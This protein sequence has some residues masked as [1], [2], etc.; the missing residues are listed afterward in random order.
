MTEEVLQK[1][2]EDGLY[3]EEDLTPEQEARVRAAVDRGVHNL[4][5]MI[6]RRLSTMPEE[7]A[8][9][10]L[11]AIAR[12]GWSSDIDERGEVTILIGDKPFLITN[13]QTLTG[14]SHEELPQPATHTWS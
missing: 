10:Y 2:R 14:M 8:A 3:D 13:V 11:D 5:R 7:V 12:K 1:D 4:E 6:V 9:G